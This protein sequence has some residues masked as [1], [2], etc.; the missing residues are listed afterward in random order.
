MINH[1]GFGRRFFWH[2]FDQ[3]HP[4][5]A[6]PNAI[7]VCRSRSATAPSGS[8]IPLQLAQWEPTEV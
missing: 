7:G 8:I 2:E 1:G 6:T 3:R 5:G 4:T